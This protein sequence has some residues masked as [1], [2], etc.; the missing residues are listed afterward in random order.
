MVLSVES[1][2][3]VVWFLCL[4]N[5][6]IDLG[7]GLGEGTCISD[8]IDWLVIPAH[9]MAQLGLH[10]CRSYRV[11]GFFYDVLLT[12]TI[13]MVDIIIPKDLECIHSNGSA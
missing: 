12:V 1:R 9:L 2:T 11:L 3:I 7:F 13:A 4:H 6:P 10:P 8:M 5:Q